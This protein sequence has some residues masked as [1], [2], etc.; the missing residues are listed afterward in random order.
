MPNRFARPT[1]RTLLIVRGVADVAATS[2]RK[3]APATSASH[4]LDSVTTIDKLERIVNNISILSAAGSATTA[5]VGRADRV[6]GELAPAALHEVYAGSADATTASG[7]ALMLAIR[8]AKAKPIVVVRDDQCVRSAGRIYGN[9]VVD[10]GGDPEQLI[11]VHARDSLATLRAAGDAVA[12]AAVGAVIVEP[13]AAA[14]GFDLTASRR[15]VLRAANSGVFTLIVRIGVEP[16]PSAAA[17]RWHVRAAPSTPLEA[18]APGRPAFDITL[19]RHRG[20]IAEFNARV[21][22]DR[23]DRQ[24]CDAPLPGRVPAVA[25][26]G[27]GGRG[28][29][30]AA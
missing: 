2:K 15:I 18:D 6:L 22:W 29:C 19:L 30:R 3:D 28:E 17:T 26:G 4:L 1:A 24:F 7:F 5:Q 27:A 14:P 12:C 10:L 25:A 13:W 11:I 21:E 16:S 20:G 23:D 9:G 8:A